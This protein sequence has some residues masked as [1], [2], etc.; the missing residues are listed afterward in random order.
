MHQNQCG[1]WGVKFLCDTQKMCCVK[2]KM[3]YFVLY[4]FD[5]LLTFWQDD[6]IPSMQERLA[7]RQYRLPLHSAQPFHRSLV[8]KGK[9]FIALFPVL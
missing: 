6:I 4:S 5:L 8:K 3:L 9:T 7:F 1:G 2:M